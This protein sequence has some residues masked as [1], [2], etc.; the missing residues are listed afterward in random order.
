MSYFR[1]FFRFWFRNR[2][3]HAARSALWHFIFRY[4]GTVCS[5][6][7]MASIFREEINKFWGTRWLYRWAHSPSD[8]HFYI[9]TYSSNLTHFH[10]ESGGGI[11]PWNAGIYQN[12]HFH[13]PGDYNMNFHCYLNVKSCIHQL[14]LFLSLYCEKQFVSNSEYEYRTISYYQYC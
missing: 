12:V 7:Y 14:D 10:S 6:E 5:E 9:S 1:K 2:E 3:I 11:F 13:K 4:V 8:P